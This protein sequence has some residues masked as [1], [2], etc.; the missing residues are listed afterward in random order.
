MRVVLQSSL[1]ERCNKF[2][3][4]KNVTGKYTPYCTDNRCT[5]RDTLID[6]IR[7]SYSDNKQSDNLKITNREEDKIKVTNI[8]KN[9]L[10]NLDTPEAVIVESINYQIANLKYQLKELE[11][12]KESILQLIENNEDYLTLYNTIH[13]NREDVKNKHYL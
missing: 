5:F 3:K 11:R 2:Y 13:Y 10:S 4:Q 1:C 6:N 7:K 9:N 8:N 12:L